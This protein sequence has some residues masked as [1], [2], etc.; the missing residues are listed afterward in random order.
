M[1][2]CSANAPCIAGGPFNFTIGSLKREEALTEDTNH[3]F[4]FA[5]HNSSF[6]SADG[7]R[8]QMCKEYESERMHMV[9]GVGCL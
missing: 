4:V 1:T 7:S 8:V 9:D 2:W 5:L 3:D 6:K